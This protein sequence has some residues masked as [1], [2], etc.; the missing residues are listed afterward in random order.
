M[1]KLLYLLARILGDLKA[2]EKGRAGKRIVRRGLGK[3]SGKI[4]RKLTK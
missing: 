3:V 4:L 1:R 2:L